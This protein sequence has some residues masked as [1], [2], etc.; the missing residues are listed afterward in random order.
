MLTGLR[1]YSILNLP[2]AALGASLGLQVQMPEKHDCYFPHHF[3]HYFH[4]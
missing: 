1:A 3:V 4:H 2:K